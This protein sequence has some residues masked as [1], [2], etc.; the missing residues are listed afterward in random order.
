MRSAGTAVVVV[1]VRVLGVMTAMIKLVNL[2][3]CY[4][5]H[6][7]VHHVSGE[8]LSGS[9]T[10][11]VGPNGAGKSTLL[12]AIMG[13]LPLQQGQII[14]QLDKQH[15]A[16][17]AQQTRVNRQFPLSVL[18]TVNQGHWQ[19]LGLSQKLSAAQQTASLAAL[20]AVGLAGFAQ[21]QVNSLSSGQFQR[22]LFARIIAQDCPLILLD[23]PFNAVDARTTHDL[24][25]VIQ[26]WSAQGRTVIA[27]L[28]DFDQVRQHFPHALLLAREVLAWGE[29]HDVLSADNL[30]RAKAM[31]ESWDEQARVCLR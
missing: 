7:A 2:T 8:F 5:R 3:V 18:D 30:R 9:L 13:L 1:A 25:S 17:L 4:Q 23:E 26:V 12:H 22:V 19:K 10:A 11:I 31:A 24:I 29:S 14:H 28:H 6:P 16:Y 15:I 20:N 21:R 27:V